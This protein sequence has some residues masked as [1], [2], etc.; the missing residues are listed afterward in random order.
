MDLTQEV[1]I[2]VWNKLAKFEGRSKIYTW[3]YR[4]AT[5]EAL[6]FLQKKNRMQLVSTS[7][8]TV[9]EAQLHKPAPSYMDAAETDLLLMRALA[10]LPAKQ[11]Q[12][13]VLR[14]YDEMPYQDMAEA[15]QTSVGALKASFHHAA[16]KIEQLIK[17][18]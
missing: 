10:E 4:V 15:L 7:E 9:H 13:F 12:V 14:F 1:F 8:E 11:R 16:K 18:D 5:N 3:L 17:G 6:A 2:K